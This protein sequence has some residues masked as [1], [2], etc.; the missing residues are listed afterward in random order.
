M[1]FDEKPRG[2]LQL[3]LLVQESLLNWEVPPMALPLVD[4]SP[5]LLEGQC[6]HLPCHWTPV[7]EQNFCLRFRGS[8]RFEEMRPFVSRFRGLGPLSLRLPCAWPPVLWVASG[9][10]LAA[11]GLV[12]NR[13]HFRNQGHRD[14]NRHTLSRRSPSHLFLSHWTRSGFVFDLRKWQRNQMLVK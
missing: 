1:G 4:D 3:V 5:F 2:L 10:P 13:H 12:I 7:Y 8:R 14:M 6:L 11:G 9:D